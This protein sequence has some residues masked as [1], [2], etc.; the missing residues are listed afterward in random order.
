MDIETY[1]LTVY[2][3]DGNPIEIPALQ[4]RGI[5]SISRTSGNGT[6][7]S[8]DIY[9]IT[10]SDGTTSQ[11]QI[12]N[13]KDGTPYTLT[14]ADKSAIASAAAGMIDAPVTSV[15]GKTGAIQLKAADVGALPSTTTIPSKTSQLADDVGYARESDLS[16]LSAE[17]EEYKIPYIVGNSTTAGTWTGTYDGI[18]E[19]RDGLTVLYKIN[20]EGVS[21]G[22]TLDINGLGAKSVNRNA[23]TAVTTMYPVGTVLMLTY[24]GGAWLTADYDAN[25]KNTAGTSNKVGTKMYLAG[26][27]SQTSSGTTTYTNKNVYIGTDNCLYSNGEKVA[28]ETQVNQFSETIAEQKR[29]FAA[30]ENSAYAP[31]PQLPANGQKAG[32]DIG[33]GGRV[34][35]FE[36]AIDPVTCTLNQ[37][38]SSTGATKDAPGDIFTDYIPVK[39]TDTI[40]V[41]LPLTNL[42]TDYSR[43][44]FYSG[45]PGSYAYINSSDAKLGAQFTVNENDGVCS[46][47]LNTYNGVALGATYTAI[48]LVL[49]INGTTEVKADDIADL[50]V[51]VNEPISYTELP[52]E[53]ATVSADFDG[54]NITAQD[55]YNY[56]D[57]L[58]SKYPRLITKEVMGKDA[59]NT[60]D[61]CRYVFGRRAYDAWMRQNYPPM[62][63]WVN[64]SAVIYSVSVSPRIGDTLYTTKYVG[65]S[66]GT[67]TAVN[68]ANQTRTVGGVVYTRDK[69]K[70]VEP[71]LVYTETP[72]STNHVGT[73][74]NHKN[75]VTRDNNGVKTRV[76][77]IVSMDG[78]TMVCNDTR[79]Y[80][81][82]PLA[83]R[84][85]EYKIKPT[86]LIGANEHGLDS[87]GSGDA[88]EPAII[89]ARLAK[90]LCEC[91]PRH[92]YLNALR[93]NYNIVLVP[94]INPYGYTV[95]KYTNSRN[96]NIDR[97]FDTPGWGKDT[98]DTR[99]GEYGG[100]E[101]ETQYWMN[102]CVASKAVV[103][104]ANHSYGH[105]VDSSTGEITVAGTCGCLIP[106]PVDAYDEYIEH[107]EMVM[108]SYNLSLI[109]SNSA[110]PESHAKTRSYMDW[111][112]IR[113]CALEMQASEGFLLD[114]GGQRF[115]ERVME[116]DYT[117]LLQ[118]LYMLI[119]NQQ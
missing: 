99:H 115:T 102:T 15:N 19:Y 63:A 64:G 29:N 88:A 101:N 75:E 114:G 14:D 112:G 81:R 119:T 42:N 11:F 108:N 62:Y 10:Y 66:K 43:V 95:G 94:V 32:D 18:T 91:D 12:Y 45:A 25:T 26:A 59:S 106:R 48:R 60:Y 110:E 57:K 3:N 58:V 16:Q 72:Y 69:T 54:D 79:T 78:D 96:V 30:L 118:F 6:A 76:G 28:T 52:G 87:D 4:G 61:C 7:G 36:N 111:V 2:D 89:T 92:A 39:S 103:G 116:A 109:F 56:M 105:K 44:K 40:Y 20:V 27:T 8:R 24:S 97:N 34:P 68:N 33:G 65:T 55:I 67:V 113:C 80:I 93:E 70:D 17:I 74:A 37:R 85:S 21:G 86:I 90:D 117:M 98:V 41:N 83:D 47:A 50:I 5:E 9:T 31:I 22:T 53:K 107:I 51:T 23:S 49:D 71:T 100:S 82:Y 46:F 38:I 84:D 77:S 104:M 35:N 13:G 1:I 73:Y